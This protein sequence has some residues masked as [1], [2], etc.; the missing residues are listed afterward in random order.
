MTDITTIDRDE[1]NGRFKSG[2]I[3]GPG[4][5]RGNRN[6]LGELFLENLRDAWQEHGA[7]ALRRCAIEDPAAFVRVIA[8]LLPK[9]IDLNMTL[10][11]AAFADKWRQASELLGH[12]VT[13][14]N[15]RRSLRTVKVLDH[16]G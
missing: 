4:R 3:G 16:G 10:D 7:E 1:R 13:M 9:T 12:D 2:N 11:A 5:G 8:G 14:P 15:P 6:K